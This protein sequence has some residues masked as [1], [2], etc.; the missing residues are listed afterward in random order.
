ML[1]PRGCRAKL[2]LQLSPYA[3]EVGKVGLHPRDKGLSVE[4]A[5]CC[6]SLPQSILIYACIHKT[7]LIIK[8]HQ[9]CTALTVLLSLTVSF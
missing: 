1:S 9:Y 6:Y 5:S 3:P 2:G 4:A 7:G 8:G